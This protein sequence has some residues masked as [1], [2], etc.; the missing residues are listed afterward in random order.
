MKKFA[1]AI[2]PVAFAMA[3][4]NSPAEEAAEEQAD[5]VEVT[6]EAAGEVL[7]EQAEAADAEADAMEAAGDEAGAAA[8][9]EK[10]EAME[11]KADEM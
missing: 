1:I 7:D 2:L 10:A 4:C 11:D 5:V 8:M 9:E 3:A 6:E